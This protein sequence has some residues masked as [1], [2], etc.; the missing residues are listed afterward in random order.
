MS[1]KSLAMATGLA[2]AAFGLALIVAPARIARGWIGDEAERPNVKVLVRA[3]GVRDVVVG[4]GTLMAARRN[5]P[6]RGWLEGGMAAD[7]G[8]IIGTLYAAKHLPRQ[9][10]VMTVGLAALAAALSARAVRTLEDH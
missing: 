4:M 9:G 3:I 6:V 2:R 1:G 5:T 8:D 10:V 7:A